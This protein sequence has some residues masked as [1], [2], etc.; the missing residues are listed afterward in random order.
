MHPEKGKQESFSDGGLTNVVLL[1][2][3]NSAKRVISPCLKFPVLLEIKHKLN[4][5]PI[6]QR[7][8]TRAEILV[9][10]SVS[11]LNCA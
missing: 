5:V 1:E 3:E 7:V 2:A 9:S 4:S 11:G 8:L 6:R 10:T